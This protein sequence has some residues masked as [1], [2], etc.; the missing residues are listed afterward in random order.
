[1]PLHI[2]LRERMYQA[3]SF[4]TTVVRIDS[5]SLK[6]EITRS[7][8][9]WSLFKVRI[10]ICFCLAWQC[11]SYCLM[12]SSLAMTM[13]GPGP[14]KNYKYSSEMSRTRAP[15]LHPEKCFVESTKISIDPY[16]NEKL[17]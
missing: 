1:M 4:L 9:K 13:P 3:I 12:M 6:I 5:V 15:Y 7:L 14:L 17:C 10:E 2:I 8:G 16:L 11:Q